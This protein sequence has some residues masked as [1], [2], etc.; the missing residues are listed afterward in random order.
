MKRHTQTL[1]RIRDQDEIP[2]S[3][4]TWGSLDLGES[5]IL[6]LKSRS[7]GQSWRLGFVP[8]AALAWMTLVKTTA[9]GSAAMLVLLECNF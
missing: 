6:I 1:N 2:L 3:H 4:L 8:L 9:S 5:L 7:P